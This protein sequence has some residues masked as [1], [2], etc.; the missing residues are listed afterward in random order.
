[1][2]EKRARDRTL[3]LRFGVVTDDSPLTIIL[4]DSGVEYVDV[5]RLASYATPVVD[6]F[7]VVIKSGRDLLV[8]GTVV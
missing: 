6:D 5:K 4:G 8:L 3:V 7:V 1:M 2:M